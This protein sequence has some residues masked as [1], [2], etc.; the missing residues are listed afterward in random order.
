MKIFLLEDELMLQHSIAEYLENIGHICIS[1]AS[2]KEALNTISK[3][4]FDLLILDINVPDINGLDLVLELNKQDINSKILFISALN[5]IETI[6]KAYNCG[7]KDY[8]KKPFHLKELA[9]RLQR[10]IESIADC[11]SAHIILSKNYSFSLEEK[12]LF[13]QTKEEILTKRH[14]DI[15]DCLCKN[16]NHIVTLDVIREYVWQ[17]DVSDATIRSEISRLRKKLKEEFISNHKGIG[18][19]VNRYISSYT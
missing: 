17:S 14:L 8:I 3:E 7:A 4:S 10:V 18:Y 13:F 1:S 11:K 15:I 6:E 2:G 9:L 5:D 19:R 16:L 12:K